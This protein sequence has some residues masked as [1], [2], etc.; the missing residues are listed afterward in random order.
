MIQF[1]DIQKLGFKKES[2]SDQVYEN[3]HGRP[4][5]YMCFYASIACHGYTNEIVFNWDCDSLEV[6]VFKNDKEHI[7]TF[8]E[9]EDFIKFFS[10]FKNK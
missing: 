2:A 1:V 10:V 7:F 4:Y 9:Y 6:K 3:Q 8:S 5:W